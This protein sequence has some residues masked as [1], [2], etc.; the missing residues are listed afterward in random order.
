MSDVFFI[1]STGFQKEKGLI[2]KTENFPLKRES[3]KW[4]FSHETHEEKFDFL[5]FF[6]ATF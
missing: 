1:K 4:T 3:K 2:D 6:F 5:I